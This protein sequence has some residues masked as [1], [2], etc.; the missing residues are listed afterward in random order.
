M[1]TRIVMLLIAATALHADDRGSP[2][3]IMGIFGIA[4]LLLGPPIGGVVLG[5]L[6]LALYKA[7]VKSGAMLT[8]S[9]PMF[10]ILVLRGM[11]ALIAVIAAVLFWLKASGHALP[12]DR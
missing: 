9:V 8:E 5:F 7:L 6:Q 3:I 2:N 12:Y 10:P 11:I 1:G 4:L